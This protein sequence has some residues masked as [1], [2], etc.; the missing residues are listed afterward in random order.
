MLCFAE[1]L[2]LCTRGCG[3][4]FSPND[5][6]IYLHIIGLSPPGSTRAMEAPSGKAFQKVLLVDPSLEFNVFFYS[7][8]IG[9]SDNV[10]M[11]T[12]V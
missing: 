3:V 8:F 4:C 2:G 9:V 11:Y 6:C 12:P 10:C 5:I 1:F 7:L